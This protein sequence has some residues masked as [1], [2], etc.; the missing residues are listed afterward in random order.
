MRTRRLL[1][2]SLSLV[3]AAGV[4]GQV[5][6]A[7]ADRDNAPSRWDG[8]RTIKA[9]ERAA[10]DVQ[11]AADGGTWALA[12]RQVGGATGAD[13]WRLRERTDDGRWGKPRALPAT[14]DQLSFDSIPAGG[15]TLGAY[16][17]DGRLWGFLHYPGN[18]GAETEG[19]LHADPTELGPAV[20][21]A[22]APQVEADAYEGYGLVAYAGIVHTRFPGSTSNDNPS[23]PSWSSR[24][25][26]GPA[27]TRYVPYDGV[28]GFWTDDASGDLMVSDDGLPPER[29]G[30]GRYVDFVLTDRGRRLVSQG[31]DGSVTLHDY[32][33]VDETTG[34]R[35]FTNP[36]TLAG[37]SA[38][39]PAPTVLVD[40]G[41]RL[42][43]GWREARAKGG[44]VLWQEDRYGSRYLEEPTLV[45][46]S[47]GRAT[48]VVTSPR[49]TLT[50]ATQRKGEP[51]VVR[52]KHLPAGTSSWTDG[53]RLVSPK[54]PSA[55]GAS[56]LSAPDWQGDL[57]LAVN[58]A[59]GTYRFDF[60]APDAYTRVV[61]PTRTV[62]TG[63][64]YRVG[65]ETAWAFAPDWQ[66]RERR[67]RGRTYGDWKRIEVADGVQSTKV[68]KEPGSTWCFSA[69]GRA[70]GSFTAWSPQRCVTVRR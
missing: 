44:L 27:G 67:D 50:V 69:R 10:D 22:P 5:P 11:V 14:V 25:A 23:L 64:T 20:A 9:A 41:E 53:V 47:R 48:D 37:P 51:G 38:K 16:V 62:R 8:A 65:W 6:T 28:L 26:F 36:R 30:N 15:Y 34:R 54:R 49:G 55:I 12:A 29:V 1:G 13:T 3:V 21:G 33:V 63:T 43:V 42:T 18:P 59:A 4:A 70:G 39:R 31:T 56:A 19:T 40:R 61:K 58:D 24:P 17:A 7:A 2:A 57:L 52:V 32:G 35:G 45:P 66:V 60:H 68:T 46:G